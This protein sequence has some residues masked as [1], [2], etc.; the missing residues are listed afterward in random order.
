M[1]RRKRPV[2]TDAEVVEIFR[3]FLRERLESDLTLDP[4][5]MGRILKLAELG[6]EHEKSLK[7]AKWAQERTLARRVGELQAR[8]NNVPE[9]RIRRLIRAMSH[10]SR[11]RYRSDAAFAKYLQRIRRLP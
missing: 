7:R 2:G 9:A 10:V 1:V 11:Y 6:L 8:Y 5:L 4:Y 3:A